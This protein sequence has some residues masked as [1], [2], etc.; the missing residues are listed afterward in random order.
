M[1][2]RARLLAPRMR[3]RKRGLGHGFAASVSRLSESRQRA[4]SRWGS[5]PTSSSRRGA[6]CAGGARRRRRRAVAFVVPA[7]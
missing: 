3:L 6:A 2:A 5:R 7:R 4:P 1:S